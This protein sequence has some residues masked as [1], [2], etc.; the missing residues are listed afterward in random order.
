MKVSVFYRGRAT[1]QAWVAGLGLF[2]LMSLASMTCQ[3]QTGTLFSSKTA[4][5]N[6]PGTAALLASASPVVST[7][8]VRAELLAHAPQ[9]IQAGQTFWLGLQIEHQP[10][11]HT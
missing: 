10:H 5:S 3:A 8:Q 6:A 11:W 7:E 4:A 2:A 9:G 1:V